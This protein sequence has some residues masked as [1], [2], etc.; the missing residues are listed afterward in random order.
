MSVCVCVCVCAFM[1]NTGTICKH[2]C[3]WNGL[4][5]NT[6]QHHP[7]TKHPL[8]FDEYDW[9]FQQYF[10]VKTQP[11]VPTAQASAHKLPLCS[12]WCTNRVLHVKFVLVTFSSFLYG[13]VSERWLVEYYRFWRRM[14]GRY[15]RNAIFSFLFTGFCYDYHRSPPCVVPHAY[16][17][18]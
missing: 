7:A 10:L 1:C 18:Q 5:D 2:V 16:V 8:F 4:T 6:H 12:P 9:T 11:V 17:M 13:R 15:S 14:D 3:V